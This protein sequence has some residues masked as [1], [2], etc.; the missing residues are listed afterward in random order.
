M[1]SII[2]CTP[3]GREILETAPSK[4]DENEKSSQKEE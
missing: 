3:L 4:E 2:W 1:T